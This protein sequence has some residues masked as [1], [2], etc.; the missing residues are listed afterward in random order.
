MPNPRIA[1]INGRKTT[2]V[3]IILLP[4]FSHH[5]KYIQCQ[6]NESKDAAK[7]DIKRYLM[8][9]LID[10]SKRDFQRNIWYLVGFILIIVIPI[11]AI[12]VSLSILCLSDNIKISEFT[13]HQCLL[14]FERAEATH[15]KE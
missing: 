15:H 5:V 9:D 11:T 3:L 10:F 7:E 1:N 2:F 6:R 12:L 13:V 8:R 14:R 4:L